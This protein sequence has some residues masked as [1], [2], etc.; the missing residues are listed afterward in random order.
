MLLTPP[1]MIVSP[2][3]MLEHMFEMPIALSVLFGS[4]LRRNGSIL[5]MAAIVAS[6]STPSIRVRVRTVVNSAHQSEWLVNSPWKFGITMPCLNG[7]AG[8]WI[9]RSPSRPRNQPEDQ[10]DHRRDHLR[11]HDLHPPRLERRQREDQRQAEDPHDEDLRVHRHELRRR[12]ARRCPRTRAPRTC[13]PKISGSCLAMIKSPIAAS[14]PSTTE[15]GKIAAKRASLNLAR[16]TCTDARQADGA[17][18]E[19]IADLH[20]RPGRAAA[21][22]RRAPAPA[23]R[24]AR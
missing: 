10:P 22:R 21:S 19:R 14:I 11:R 4:D 23:R 15:A 17:Q 12:L 20:G 8:M 6:D 3:A 9:R 5:S 2:P 18:Q 13:V 24:P 1:G 16:T 7:L